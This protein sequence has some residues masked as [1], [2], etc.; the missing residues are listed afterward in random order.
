LIQRL[1]I[2]RFLD[3]PGS[4]R[5]KQ[6]YHLFYDKEL[7][8]WRYGLL[9]L[10]LSEPEKSL[11]DDFPQKSEPV[12]EAGLA[13][14]LEQVPPSSSIRGFLNLSARRLAFYWELGCTQ[15][16]FVALDLLTLINR[17]EWIEVGLA[18]EEAIRSLHIF[19]FPLISYHFGLPCLYTDFLFSFHQF[20]WAQFVP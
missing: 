15:A 3:V 17:K 18:S 13:K 7:Y 2:P 4:C 5:F 10:L 19:I 1:E 11:T 6:Q 20:L 9:L 16:F 14:E 8:Q 12:Q